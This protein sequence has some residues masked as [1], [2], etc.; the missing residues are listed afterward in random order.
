MDDSDPSAQSDLKLR[1][2]SLEEGLH[3]TADRPD[4]DQATCAFLSQNPTQDRILDVEPVEEAVDREG[5]H[6]AY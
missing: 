6:V 3:T 1:V 4:R 2:E 5:I